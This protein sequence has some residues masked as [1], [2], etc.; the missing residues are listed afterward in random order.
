MAL[1]D[2][3]EKLY[4]SEFMNHAICVCCVPIAIMRLFV[5]LVA[6]F[7]SVGAVML[8][9]V[10]AVLTGRSYQ[11]NMDLSYLP[12]ESLLR[13]KKMDCSIGTYD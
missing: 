1:N 10:I 5:R 4:S 7:C 11:Q 3:L 8:A 9:D 6:M 12:T 2:N 13:Q